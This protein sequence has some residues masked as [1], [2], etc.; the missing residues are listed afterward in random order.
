MTP[1]D[2]LAV[3]A[4][5]TTDETSIVMTVLAPA[6]AAADVE[7]PLE[8]EKVLVISVRVRV[9]GVSTGTNPS[10]VAVVMRENSRENDVGVEELEETAEGEAAFVS[11]RA[12]E[13]VVSVDVADSKVD[14]PTNADGVGVV[15]ELGWI[16]K[17]PSEETPDIDIVIE[18][19]AEVDDSDNADK[20]EVGT[21]ELLELDVRTVSAI[22]SGFEFSDWTEPVEEGIGTTAND[23]VG[24][25]LDTTVLLSSCR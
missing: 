8:A 1:D 13:D 9:D 24:V 25:G 11:G 10:D 16:V 21:A 18:S 6:A 12:E 14:V 20:L 15:L 2:V 3:V 4:P 17:P 23:S 5:E 22:E 7:V 19:T